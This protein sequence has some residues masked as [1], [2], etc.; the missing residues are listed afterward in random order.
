MSF[1]SDF[2]A[3]IFGLLL[4][5]ITFGDQPLGTVSGITVGNLD[6]I[7]GI[8]LWPVMDVIYPLF[9]IAVFLLYGWVKSGEFR[10]RIE[11]FLVFSSFL[12]LLFLISVDDVAQ[13]F[14]VSFHFSRI[15]LMAVSWAFLILG[16]LI[17]LVYG[18][19]K[20]KKPK[21]PS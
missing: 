4:V 16:G 3:L 20:E 8:R 11:T 13:V 7:F 5:F 1:K 12:A 17:F 6:T 2:L 15:I 18:K 9:A 10:V 19:L 21:S 14:D